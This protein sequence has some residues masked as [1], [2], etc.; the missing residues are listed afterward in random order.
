MNGPGAAIVAVGDELL[1]GELADRNSVWLAEHL[2]ALGRRVEQVR[3]VADDE[4]LIARVLGEL[5]REHPLVITTGGL[6]PTL[7]DVT[8]HAA[9]R[10]SARELV[11]DPAVLTALEAAHRER[12][13]PM[14]ASNERQALFPRGAQVLPNPVGTA[15]GFA[16][17]VGSAWLFA[18][19]GPP[20][21]MRA[22][23]EGAVA[24]RLAS[25]PGGGAQRHRRRLHLFGVSESEFADR[26]GEW[27]RRDA[28][29]RMGVLAHAGILTVKVEAPAG[30]DGERLVEARLSDLRSR[31]GSRVFGADGADLATVVGEALIAAARPVAVAESCTGGLVAR[32][33]VAVPGISAVFREGFVTYADEAKTAR[34]GVA[35]DLLREHGAVS[36][37]VAEA[38]ARGAAERAG[39]RLAVATTGIAGPGGGSPAKPVGL[40]W[41][42]VARDGAVRAQRRTF[43]PRGR[44]VVQEWAA[45]T[46]LDLLR[47]ALEQGRDA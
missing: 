30:D 21:E 1:D 10:A 31:F 45:L 9:S 40:V 17:G 4:E 28:R 44:R 34:L 38:M 36:A 16:V 3:L 23:F 5:C 37:P 11:V 25:L 22:V 13:L 24:P 7:D 15:P 35:P 19:P 12:G 29:P 41:F 8:R 46:A 42:A 27:M 2:T 18:L 47:S 43:P 14:P 32:K 20:L 26:A 39:A 33:L 6:G